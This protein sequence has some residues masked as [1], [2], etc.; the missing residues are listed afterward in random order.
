MKIQ[1]LGTAAAEGWPGI[2]CL[3]D[4]CRRA[5]E[6]GGKNIRTRSQAIIDDRL[7]IDFPPDS[8]LHMLKNNVDLPHIKNLLI[9]HTHHDH[10]AYHELEYKNNTYV[11]GKGELLNIYG[12]DTV[13]RLVDTLPNNRKR[14]IQCHELTEFE[15]VN[16]DGYLVT[17]LLALHNRKEKCFIYMIE[18]DGKRL[19][20]A[21][22]TGFFPEKTC[23]HIASAH[24]DYVSL[25][26]TML[27][28][29]DGNNHMGLKDVFK[30]KNNLVK[31][32]CVDERTQFVISHFSHSGEL[33]HDEIESLATP[34]NIGVAYDGMTVLF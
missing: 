10:F 31:M 23:D 27:A 6:L 1:Y 29:P 9:T 26:C 30:M 34:K 18:R 5:R 2:F 19:L 4:Q 24:F 14:N 33:L 28:V 25:D 12:N 17:A 21:H 13:C 3:C 8:Y 32:G 15:A 16:I 7:L 20:Y 11:R 22:D